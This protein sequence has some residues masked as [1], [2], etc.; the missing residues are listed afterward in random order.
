MGKVMKKFIIG[1]MCIVICI[2]SYSC[3]FRDKNNPLSGKS[4]E[5]R[6]IMALEKA[7]PGHKFKMVKKFDTYNGNYYGVFKDENGLKFKVDNIIYDNIYHFG[8]EDEYLVEILKQEDF[9]EIASKIAR[10]Y[11]YTMKIDDENKT[12]DV[13]IPYSDN[14]TAEHVATVMKE[15]LNSVDVPEMYIENEEFSTGE[16]NYYSSSKMRSI[17]YEFVLGDKGRMASDVVDFLEKNKSVEELSVNINARISEAKTNAA[18]V[19]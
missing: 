16:V 9:I 6:T 13:S 10:K 14:V 12:V 1:M 4:T 18:A 11:G 17:G 5:E 2:T 19:Q 8:C 7:Y 3:V 15:I